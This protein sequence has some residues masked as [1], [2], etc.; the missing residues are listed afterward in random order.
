[1]KTLAFVLEIFVKDED[2]KFLVRVPN[3]NILGIVDSFDD[4][5]DIIRPIVESVPVSAPLKEQEN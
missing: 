4:V 3:G 1:M 2:T 5:N